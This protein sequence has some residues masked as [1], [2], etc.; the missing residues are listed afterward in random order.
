MEVQAGPGVVR[1]FIVPATCGVAAALLG[2]WLGM[3]GD[4]E[5]VW[6]TLGLGIVAGLSAGSW[7]GVPFAVGGAALAAVAMVVIGTAYPGLIILICAVLG[8]LLLIGHLAGWIIGRVVHAPRALVYDRR[9]GG[10]IAALA[11]LGLAA[12]WVAQELARNP[13]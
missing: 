3:P 6:I 5:F 10:G 4:G 8:G 13:P 2:Y 7:R 1:T 12:W 11:G 9:V